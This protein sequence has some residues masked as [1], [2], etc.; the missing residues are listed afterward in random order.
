M[1]FVGNFLH[2][3]N[4]DAVTWLIED[5]LP[6]VHGLG[7]TVVGGNP[8][9]HL[10]ERA[11][12]RVS[13]AGYVP[14]MTPYLDA[15]R[16]SVAPLRYG[17]GMKGKI[18]EAMAAG[19]PVVTTPIGAEGMGLVD[20]MSALISST[21]EGFA[22]AVT[23]LAGDRALWESIAAAGRAL[24]GEHWTPAAAGARVREVLEALCPSPDR[25][26]AASS[27]ALAGP[28]SS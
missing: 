7:L 19:L 24:V 15:A 21:A 27:P 1:L 23:Q 10:V 6:K 2:G 25:A 13:F 4:V 5:I 11:G 26:P 28:K 18:G 22:A 8:P 12:P 16:V 14:D 3:P 20:G 9:Q 17:A